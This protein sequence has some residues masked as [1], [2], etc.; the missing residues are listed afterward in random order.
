MVET[1]LNTQISTVQD[2]S[3]D[4]ARMEK[5]ATELRASLL[6]LLVETATVSESKNNDTVTC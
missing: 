1:A 6:E 3:R 4:V 5:E 2:L